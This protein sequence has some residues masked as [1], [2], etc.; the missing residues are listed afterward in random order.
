MEKQLVKKSRM[1]GVLDT[2]KTY[3]RT[4]IGIL[5]AFLVFFTFL[6]IMSEHFL[7]SGNMINVLR[8]V[9][10]NA[11]LAVGVMLCIV[12]GGID[13]SVG[14]VMALSGVITVDLIVNS[15]LPMPLAI[16]FGILSGVLAGACSGCIIAYTNMPPF[17]VT[18]A[19]QNICR[20]AAYLIA[21]GNPIR[22]TQGMFEKI[23]TGYIG[24]IPLPVIY[25]LVIL[26]LA[27]L[28]LNK[29]MVGRYI[30]AIGGNKEAAKFSGINVKKVEILVYTISGFL[31]AFSGIVYAARMA[32]GQPAVAVGFETDAIS[33]VVVG[34]VSMT[35]GTGTLGG[36]IL[37]AFLIGI[38]SNGLNL[39]RV[40]SFWQYVVKGIIILIAVYL[41][42]MRRRKERF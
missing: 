30:Y 20:G 37:G 7:T 15:G 2:G 28:L 19:M 27:Y 11:N 32:S 1:N 42:I 4:N 31:A 34:G 10:T 25:T 24:W 3:F 41:D 17:I 26:V 6:S 39:I 29:S 18:L 8:Q 16:A 12:I 21:G 36:V 38:I 33:A 5:G 35:G 9:T 14:S 22:I 40:S 23:G 13:L